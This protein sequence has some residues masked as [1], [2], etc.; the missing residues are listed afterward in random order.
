M[1]HNAA[2]DGTTDP[3][4]HSNTDTSVARAVCGQDMGANTST[5]APPAGMHVERLAVQGLCRQRWLLL[6]R[7]HLLAGLRLPNTTNAHPNT[8]ALGGPVAFSDPH[9][10]PCAERLEVWRCEGMLGHCASPL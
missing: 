6:D 4:A 1:V 10:D 7:G 5:A 3:G 8:C 9:P 2:T